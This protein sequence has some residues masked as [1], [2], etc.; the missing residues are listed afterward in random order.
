MERGLIFCCRPIISGKKLPQMFLVEYYL[1]PVF[2]KANA[3]TETRDNLTVASVYFVA[4]V[5]KRTH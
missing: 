2:V 1:K 4:V 3:Q 5:E